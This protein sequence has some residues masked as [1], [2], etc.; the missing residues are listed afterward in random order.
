MKKLLLIIACAS[1]VFSWIAEAQMKEE[2]PSAAKT[3]FVTKFPKA[4]K[5]KW[6]IEKP[7]EFEVEFVMNGTESSALF[8]ANGSFIESETEIKENE[9]PQAVKAT[10]TKDFA[11]Y[12]LDEI[13]KVTDTKE[14][15]TYEMEAKKDKVEYELVFDGN[16]LLLKKDEVKEEEKEKKE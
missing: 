12:K 14:A 10:L 5:A 16:G 8:D 2:T 7:G 13:E 15:V 9:L 1:F 11:G 4:Q 6:S 3:A